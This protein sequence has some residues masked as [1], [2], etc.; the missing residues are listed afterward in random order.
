MVAVGIHV[1]RHSPVDVDVLAFPEQ[2]YGGGRPEHGSNAGRQDSGPDG[3][4]LAGFLRYGVAQRNP[5]VVGGPDAIDREVQLARPTHTP[6]LMC[7]RDDAGRSGAFRNKYR[8]AG[9][10]G[11]RYGELDGLTLLGGRRRNVRGQAPP[12]LGPFW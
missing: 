4:A 12:D 7:L 10:N 6:L 5:L 9:P 8:I 2:H 11:I 1:E 3:V